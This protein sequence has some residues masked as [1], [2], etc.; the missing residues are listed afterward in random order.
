MLTALGNLR[1]VSRR[2]PLRRRCTYDAAA[3]EPI[4][5]HAHSAASGRQHDA[6]SQ[7]KQHDQPTCSA[8]IKLTEAVGEARAE[9]AAESGVG[10]TTA[11]IAPTEAEARAENGVGST[12]AVGEAGAGARVESANAA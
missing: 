4:A 2:P 11:S 6:R 1:T 7:G 5:R 9:A 12:E 10:S 3:C 8:S